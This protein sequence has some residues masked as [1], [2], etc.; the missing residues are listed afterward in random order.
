MV[1]YEVYLLKLDLM[2]LIAVIFSTCLF[3]SSAY[4]YVHVYSAPALP[5]KVMAGLFCGFII[6]FYSKDMKEAIISSFT[7]MVLALILIVFTLSLPVVLGIISEPG[8]ANLF[9]IST[10]KTGISDMIFMFPSIIVSTILSY[11]L[12]ERKLPSSRGKSLNAVIFN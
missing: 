11:L 6:G 3:V 2:R 8:L 1:N 10:I 4:V 7:V 9:I 5:I 12:T